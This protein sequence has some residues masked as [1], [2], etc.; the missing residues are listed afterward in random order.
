VDA[1]DSPGLARTVGS[2][3]KSVPHAD[4]VRVKPDKAPANALDCIMLAVCRL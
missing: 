4:A 2:K 3:L 1:H